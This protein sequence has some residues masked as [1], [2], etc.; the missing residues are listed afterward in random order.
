MVIVGYWADNRLAYWS[1]DKLQGFYRVAALFALRRW[2]QVE[3]CFEG[4]TSRLLNDPRFYLLSDFRL[5][6]FSSSHHTWDSSQFP[7]LTP[8]ALS[9]LTSEMQSFSR[10][11]DENQRAIHQV[12]NSLR[13]AAL[14]NSAEWLQNQRPTKQTGFGSALTKQ[15]GSFTLLLCSFIIA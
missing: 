6:F 1:S 5:L 11:H 12:W 4:L 15:S 9:P 2:A 10:L 13:K 8:Q 3:G 14:C 7:L